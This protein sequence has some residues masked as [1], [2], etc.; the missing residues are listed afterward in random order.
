MSNTLQRLREMNSQLEYPDKSSEKVRIK[1]KKSVKLQLDQILY[2]SI[3]ENPSTEVNN[4]S[5]LLGFYLLFVYSTGDN[6]FTINRNILDDYKATYSKE[7]SDLR[8]TIS[9]MDEDKKYDHIEISRIAAYY[10]RYLKYH[11]E[12]KNDSRTILY[13]L[14]L[15][16][17]ESKFREIARAYWSKNSN[18]RP[19][20]LF[21]DL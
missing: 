20:F 11:A 3:I 15:F 4:I 6:D 10:L 16:C 14:A 12:L 18:I 7:E 19:H 17:K 2:S 5:A 9:Y 21:S 13:L 8:T 1:I